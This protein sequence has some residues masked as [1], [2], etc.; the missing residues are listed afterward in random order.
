MSVVTAF[1]PGPRTE[2]DIDDFAITN[3]TRV[4]T[5]GLRKTLDRLR[6]L[7]IKWPEDPLK[8]IRKIEE[9]GDQVH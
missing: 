8:D 2:W 6:A 9:N 3:F 1:G 7:D 4:S 5:E